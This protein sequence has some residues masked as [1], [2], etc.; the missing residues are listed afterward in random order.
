[1]PRHFS[2]PITSNTKITYSSG[3]FNELSACFAI[4]Q[5]DYFASGFMIYRYII[6]RITLCYLQFLGKSPKQVLTKPPKT[7]KVFPIMNSKVYFINYILNYNYF[8]IFKPP[9]RGHLS[10]TTTFLSQDWPVLIT[11]FNWSPNLR[12]HSWTLDKK[13]NLN[14]TGCSLLV[15]QLYIGYNSFPLLI[16]A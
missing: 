10:Q 11:R 4:D 8:L 16:Y 1:M 12:N 3:R 5:S 6:L 9:H 14:G 13:S 7:I 15:V 2:D